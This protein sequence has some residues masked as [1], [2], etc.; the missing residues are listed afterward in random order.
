[1][2]LNYETFFGT[3]PIMAKGMTGVF[4]VTVIIILSMYLLNRLTEKE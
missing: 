3:L 2:N 4:L 1:M